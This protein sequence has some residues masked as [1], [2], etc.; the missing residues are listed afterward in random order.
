MERA[1]SCAKSPPGGDT[2]THIHT[3]P[4]QTNTVMENNLW[5]TL[6]EPTFQRSPGNIYECHTIVDEGPKQA[7]LSALDIYPKKRVKQQRATPKNRHWKHA[8][9]GGGD[10]CGGG[11]KNCSIRAGYYWMGMNA[12]LTEEST[13]PPTIRVCFVS[14]CLF[15]AYERKSVD[16][17]TFLW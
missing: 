14:A 9:Y 17:A 10:G 11:R 6:V 16:M 3:L 7:R 8:A 13:S 15:L 1:P 5:P 12:Y 2:H 4:Q